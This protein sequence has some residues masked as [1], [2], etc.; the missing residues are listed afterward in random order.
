MNTILK[1]KGTCKWWNETK[2]FGFLICEGQSVDIFVHKSQLLKS[3]LSSLQEG[4]KI[5]CVIN[6]GLKGLYATTISK[7]C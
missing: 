3:G 2:G 6:Q 4:D 1:I 7:E 5:T